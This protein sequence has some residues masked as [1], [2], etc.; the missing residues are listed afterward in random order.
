MIDSMK[1][2]FNKL[3]KKMDI[4]KRCRTMWNNKKLIKRRKI[5]N[6]HQKKDLSL[7]IEKEQDK[8]NDDDDE[9]ELNTTTDVNMSL[10]T[11]EMIER[12]TIMTLKSLIKLINK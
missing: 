9:K 12:K 7:C 1:R 8:Y 3:N 11:N 10:S 6:E 4:M 2:E 5:K